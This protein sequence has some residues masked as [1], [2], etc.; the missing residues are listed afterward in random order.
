MLA[1]ADMLC[2][3][4]ALWRC[5]VDYLGS[6]ENAD[7]G[8]GRMRELLLSIGSTAST[9]IPDVTADVN[10]P[11]ASETEDAVEKVKKQT[12]KTITVEDVLAIC[13]VYDLEDVARNVCLVSAVEARIV[14]YFLLQV[15]KSY[16]L[17]P[18]MRDPDDGRDARVAEEVR[19]GHRVLCSSQ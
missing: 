3:D 8:L 4:P 14:E 1:Y 18:V 2:S 13:A 19:H 9:D 12:K 5:T 11:I 7:V 16:L 6:L 15:P 17:T 10:G